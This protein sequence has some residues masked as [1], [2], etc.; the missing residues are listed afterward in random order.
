MPAGRAPALRTMTRS[1]ASCGVNR[2]RMMPP[3]V[4]EMLVFDDRGRLDLLV[5]DD[6]DLLADVR[7]G[8]LLEAGAAVG[9]E[10][11][12]DGGVVPLVLGPADRP[13]VLARDH[14]DLV[15]EIE[16]ALAALGIALDD[17][18]V[19]GDLPVRRLE[20]GGLV[21][22][23]A[24]LDELPLQDGGDLDE[25]LDPL[26]VVDAG[27]LDDDLV[28]ALPLD[29]RLGDAES[30]DPVVDRLLG[31]ADRLVAEELDD[32]RLEGQVGP[33]AGEA[34][35]PVPGVLVEEV[36]GLAFLVGQRAL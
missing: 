3:E 2:P 30:V 4:R 8:D 36:A 25:L 5:E 21:G 28:R 6:G 15:D 18:G 9:V 23:G 11:E 22:G 19:V 33:V 20:E 16:A 24:G 29:E 13:Q 31:L 34:V 14:G 1:S 7:P 12:G 26:G 35:V 10:G 17:L 32:E 27:Q